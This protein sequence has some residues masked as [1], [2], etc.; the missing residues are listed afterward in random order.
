MSDSTS[1]SPS[2]PPSDASADPALD[3][4]KRGS[5]LREAA[6]AGDA[7]RVRELLEA[8]ADPDGDWTEEKAA[9]RQRTINRK[10]AEIQKT[11]DVESEFFGDLPENMRSYVAGFMA[12]TERE[13]DA[14]IRSAPFPSD[15]PL[16][17]ASESGNTECVRLLLQAGADP[18]RRDNS[19]STAMY[20]AKSAEVVRELMA[21]GVPLEDANKYGWSPLVDAVS[22]GEWGLDRLRA[23]IECGADVNA[24]HDRGYTVFMSAVS[25]MERNVEA[26]RMLVEAGADPHA[27]TELGYNAFH[28][29][30]DVDG[31]ANDE[32][33]VRGTLG[34]LKELGVDIEHR[35]TN[36]QTPLARAISFGTSLEVRVLCELG[37]DPSATQ[38]AGSCDDEDCE[39]YELPLLFLAAVDPVDGEA[40]TRALL[41]A[42]ADPLAT[43]LDGCTPLMHVVARLCEDAPDPDNAYAALLEEI[44]RVRVPADLPPERAAALDTLDAVI[45]PAVAELTKT[46][47]ISRDSGYEDTWREEH[48]GAIALLA[49]HEHWARAKD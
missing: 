19:G 23:L 24:T 14:Q 37:A 29:A 13:V 38:L 28:A 49:A 11:M 8:G 9:K 44:C 6:E 35:N 40:K 33:S 18:L 41:E 15:I 3:S 21:A 34:Y 27:V 2:D 32:E 22:D 39:T 30:I 47:P 26:M 42:G 1:P 12:E 48:I 7:D 5:L 45:R 17:L 16:F 43:D 36:G 10:V 31:E 46:N 4:S 20:S 25:S